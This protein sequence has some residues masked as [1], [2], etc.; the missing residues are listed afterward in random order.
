M[1]NGSLD[2]LTALFDELNLIVDGG[3]QPT[4]ADDLGNQFNDLID[5]FNQNDSDHIYHSQSIGIGENTGRRLDGGFDFYLSDGRRVRV[6][7]RGKIISVGDRK[8]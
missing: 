2:D 4:G 1:T 8:L 7:R 3:H 6:N 5:I